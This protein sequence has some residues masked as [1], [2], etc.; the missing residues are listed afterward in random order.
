[1]IHKIAGGTNAFFLLVMGTPVKCGIDLKI[2]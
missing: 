2:Y 1:M